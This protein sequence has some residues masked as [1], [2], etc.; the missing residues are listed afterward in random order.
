MY[1]RLYAKTPDAK[2]FRPMDYNAGATVTNLIYATLFSPEETQRLRAE[3]PALH[4]INP[5][6]IFEIR[7]AS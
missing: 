7:Q 3:L 1:H 2:R 5:G 6:W 4:E